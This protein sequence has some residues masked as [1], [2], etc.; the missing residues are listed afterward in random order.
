M[1]KDVEHLNVQQ[2]MLRNI[3]FG[4]F[5]IAAILLFEF[6]YKNYSLIYL[7]FAIPSLMISIITAK[8]AVKFKI[9]FY[10]A[11]FQAF[12]G[13]ILKKSQSPFAISDQEKFNEED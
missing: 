8:Q 2:I 10:K 5:I 6:V 12:T 7:F 13:L 11:L 1:A 3:S 9:W 4:F